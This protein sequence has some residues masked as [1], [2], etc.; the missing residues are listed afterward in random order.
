M[1]RSKRKRK[2]VRKS[3]RKRKIKRKGKSMS[4]KKSRS[5]SSSSPGPCQLCGAVG[6]IALRSV[7][8]GSHDLEEASGG[9][10]QQRRAKGSGK[11]SRGHRRSPEVTQLTS[12][13]YLNVL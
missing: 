6:L 9:L 10:A 7:S 5:S 11:V 4:V 8:S 2:S 12:P 1:R 3:I 13:N